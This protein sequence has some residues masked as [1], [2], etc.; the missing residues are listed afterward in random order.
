M[1]RRTH[2]SLTTALLAGVVGWPTAAS[3]LPNFEDVSKGYREVRSTLEES[4]LFHVWIRDKDAQMLAELPRGYERQK[5]FIAMTQP[6]GERFAGLQSG[7]RY[8]YWK[9]YNERLALIE[10]NLSIRASGD[11]ESQISVSEI[12]TDRVL[13]DLPIVCMGP[14]GQPVIDLDQLLVGNAGSFYGRSAAGLNGRLVNIK[15]AKVFPQNIEIEFEAPV[16]GGTLKSFHYSIS[17]APTNTGYKPRSADDR[18]GYFLT[19]YRDYGKYRREDVDIRNINRWHLEKADPS[20]KLSPPKEPIVFYMDHTVPVRYRRWVKAG[21][22]EWNKAFEQ[23]GIADA[24]VVHTQDATTGA[25]MEK[26]PEDVRYNFLRWLNNDI[27]TAIGPS[28]VDPTTGQILDADIVLTDGWIR[29]FWYQANE[30][31]PQIAMENFGEETLTWLKGHPEWDPRV[32][33]AAPEKRD[34]VL[35][36]IAE[37]D[38]FQ[39]EHDAHTCMAEACMAMDMSIM[40]MHLAVANLMMEGE[41]GEGEKLD[42]IPEWFVGPMV[43]SLVT[44]E[45]GHT[46][47]LRHNFKASSIYEYDEINSE[48]LKGKTPFASSVMDYNPINISMDDDLVQ[49]DYGNTGIGPYDYWAIEYGYTF[50]D[51]TKVLTR[52]AEPQLIYGTDEDS[53]GPDPLVRTY[54]LAADPLDYAENQIELVNWHRDRILDEFVKDGESWDRARR[55]YQITLNTQAS[56]ISIM[57]NWLGGAFVYRDHKGDPDGRAPHEPVPAEQQRAALDFVIENAF[58]DDAFGVTPE[59][60]A[61]MATEKWGTGAD[62]TWA[63]HDTIMGV[64]ASALTQI[65][66]PT[67]LRRIYDN[68]LLV[69]ADEDMIT[70]PEVLTQVRDAVWE[71]LED[72]SDGDFSERQP[73]I[74]SLRR[75]LQREYLDRMLSLA[76]GNSWNSAS[77]QALAGLIVLELEELEDQIGEALDSDDIMDR[78]T[79]AHLREAEKRIDEILDAGYLRTD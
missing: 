69:P 48:E 11:K 19:G 26:D 47:G 13:L 25:H 74:S 36:R 51:P 72:V 32:R 28:R 18:V 42:G 77:G 78:Y 55:G 43:K 73:M 79:L 46:L 67:T 6:G 76:R 7:S 41:G 10:P 24:M 9:R 23:I 70:L 21:V 40:S 44:H 29:V 22:L 62:S 8:V 16:G 60:L 31:L 20:L 54:D 61:H 27:S 57:S 59:L 64:Q 14:N 49:G 17:L 45:V 56:A 4:K 52:V 15:T 30:L 58:Y 35:A 65:I 2:L 1:R 38:E 5:H 66:N 63:V 50:D 75:A 71:E 3:A 53:R 34:E 12:F 68:E 39:Q 37:G 33:L